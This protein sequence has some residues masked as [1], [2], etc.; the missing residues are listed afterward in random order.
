M[1][2]LAATDLAGKPLA[3]VV[4]APVRRHSGG[5]PA[6]SST[7]S[8]ASD[9]RRTMARGTRSTSSP[10]TP[11]CS[12]STSRG[13][14]RPVRADSS[15]RWRPRTASTTRTSC[16]PT[17][18]PT[19]TSSSTR[20]NAL[21]VARVGRP[22]R[23]DPLR[24]R[25]QALGDRA[26]PT[27]P[28]LDD[29]RRAVAGRSR[30][31]RRDPRQGDTG[32]EPRP[33]PQPGP[34]L[35]RRVA[36]KA[37]RSQVPR[38]ALRR[39]TISVIV[40]F[41][42]V[43]AYLAE[44]LD[45]I[46]GQDLRATSR[47]CSSTT[48]RRTARAP[49]AERVRRAR[50]AA[51]RRHAART[52]A[53][54]P[55]A[56]PASARPAGGTSRSSTPTTCCP[57]QAL[58]ALMGSRPR[59]RAR[60]SWSARCER[61]DSR[62]RTGAVLGRAGARARRA[63][64]HHGRGASC[65][66]CA[67]STPGTRLFRRDF[68][69]AQD[70]WFRE[71]V[72]Y[73]D[74][75]I[76]T[77]LF[78]RA[79]AIDVL[80]DVVYLYR[81]RDDKQLDQP[82]DGQ[83]QGPPRPH[84]GLAG[85]PRRRSAPRCRPRSYEAWLARS[86]TPTSS[87]T[88]PARARSTTTTGAELVAAVRDLTDGAPQAVW[89]ADRAP[90]SG[91]S[92]SWPVRTGAPTPRSSSGRSGTARGQLASSRSASDGVLLRAA[93]ATATPTLPDDLFV[94]RPEQLELAHAVEKSPGSTRPTDGAH[95]SGSRAGP[96]SPRS[97][98]PRVEAGTE[99][100]LRNERDRRRGLR[101]PGHGA[102]PVAAFPPPVDDLWCDY[103]PGTFGVDVPMSEVLAAAAATGLW[104]VWLRVSVGGFTATRPVTPAR[105]ATAGRRSSRRTAGRRQPRSSRCGRPPAAA[106]PRRPH[107]REA[108]MTCAVDGRVL[109][110]PPAGAGRGRRG[111]G[112]RCRPAPARGGAVDD[113]GRR[114]G[115]RCPSRRPRPPGRPCTCGSRLGELDGGS[116]A[117]RRPRRRRAR[118]DRDGGRRSSRPTASASSWSPSGSVGA[119]ADEVA[120][121]D[122]GA[123]LVSGRVPRARRP[124]PPGTRQLKAHRR[125]A[126]R[127]ST[128]G[129]FAARLRAAPRAV[130]LRRLAAA[131]S[132]T[133]T[134]ALE[135]TTR[136]RTPGRGPAPSRRVAGQPTLPADR[137][138]RR[139]RGPGGARPRRAASA[140]PCCGRSGDARGA[141]SSTCCA[142]GP[143]R[144][145]PD[146]G[147]C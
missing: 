17:S 113:A 74:Q 126:V 5:S 28:P 116:T 32:A 106:L 123:L 63:P 77:Q 137:G 102:P 95:V 107:R 114:S 4:V 54:A 50:P 26:G 40:P 35:S 94:L 31:C 134:S 130:P 22:A 133:T 144:R 140:S 147:A 129:R 121:H 145:R 7:R 110:G 38:A 42:N 30:R 37:A 136:V 3:P 99:L 117:S 87:G 135:V 2:E 141:T 71:G 139:A 67:T 127:R 52:A 104:T 128:D 76:I 39:P 53:S 68:W 105:C 47:C 91:S 79:P 24:R 84:R 108:A 119:Y 60:T 101:L 125:P 118:P 112:R 8:S 132:V 57:L 115:S 48:A 72:A 66:C 36:R 93:A 103:T 9:L 29:V 138:H 15:C 90:T 97:T 92:S 75:P 124:A 81:A 21:P 69:D 64:R 120:V 11:A 109:T 51:P 19:G 143:R 46:V 122:D 56:T 16:S 98:S 10:S 83:P 78:A 1:C 18:A 25:R 41:Y 73:E 82:A 70:L 43:E 45:S 14:V 55:P 59:R 89:D 111:P 85:E 27:R 62:A 88:S 23:G 6:T 34:G 13:C 80:P 12:C 61:F 142:R 44:C 33:D 20:W 86:S 58:R 146:R 131:A 65:R 96:S 100:V 49:I